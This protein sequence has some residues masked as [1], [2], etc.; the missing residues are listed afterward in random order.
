MESPV[1][2][3]LNACVSTYL[4]L[5]PPELERWLNIKRNG[6]KHLGND[7]SKW[8][9]RPLPK[10]LVDYAAGDTI[11]MPYLYKVCV[12]MLSKDPEVLKIVVD[13]SKTRANAAQ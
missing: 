10:V 2:I 8:V 1:V 3:G 5:S 7:F 4:G 11:Y 12:D 13:E 6:Q 9:K